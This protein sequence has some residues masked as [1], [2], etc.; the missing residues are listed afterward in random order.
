MHKQ[1]IELVHDAKNVVKELVATKPPQPG[2][3]RFAST[4]ETCPEAT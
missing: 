3:L 2:D 1:D 4:Q